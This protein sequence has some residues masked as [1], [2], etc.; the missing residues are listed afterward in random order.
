MP[1]QSVS[2]NPTFY[3]GLYVTGLCYVA[4]AT[5]L[6]YEYAITLPLELRTVWKRR[7]NATSLLLLSIRWTMLVLAVCYILQPIQKSEVGCSIR[8]WIISVACIAGWIEVDCF[9]A[10]RISA[11]YGCNRS[12]FL[13]VFVLG[14]A[15]VI[16]NSLAAV[17]F[18]GAYLPGLPGCYYLLIT[19][20]SL[21]KYNLDYTICAYVTRS[22]LILQDVVVLILTWIKTYGQWKIARRSNFSLSVSMCL[23]R[24][25]TMYF[26]VLLVLNATQIAVF[27][28]QGSVLSNFLATVPLILTSR[29]M[30]NLRELGARGGGADDDAEAQPWSRFSSAVFART[31]SAFVG[32]VGEYL[33]LGNE[34]VDGHRPWYELDEL[35]SGADCSVL[36][37]GYSSTG[38]VYEGPSSA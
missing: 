11:I 17:S 29:F 9:I 24:D 18:R 16:T 14:L 30:M 33:D 10:F 7:W 34:A 4:T 27:R 13:L 2:I 32:N 38:A 6:F 20:I 36:E 5:C 22:T 37:I 15:P 35:E 19:E 23:L 3:G 26:C 28:T 21:E 8:I 31:G 12:L 1:I 25:G